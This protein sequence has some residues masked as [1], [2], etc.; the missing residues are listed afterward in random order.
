MLIPPRI[1]INMADMDIIE[2]TRKIFGFDAKI[3][4]RKYTRE[5]EAHFQDQYIT[6]VYGNIAIG[7]M[8]TL[9]PL[10]GIRRKAKIKEVVNKWRVSARNIIVTS[11]SDKFIKDL[12]RISGLTFEEASAQYNQMQVT[13]RET[14]N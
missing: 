1:N 11:P 6:R 12:M 8:L 10:M 9:Y 2:R 5:E 7:W 14:V 4:R 3:T 13:L